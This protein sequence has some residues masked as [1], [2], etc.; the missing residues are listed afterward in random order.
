VTSADDLVPLLFVPTIGAA[1][2]ARHWFL[3]V[4][5]GRWR[6]RLWRQAPS[7]RN[8]VSAVGVMPAGSDLVMPN[9][10]EPFFSS[11]TS[12]HARAY[13]TD[14]LMERVG[15]LGKIL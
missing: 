4:R 7:R 15:W 10:L 12:R 8:G 11:T 5:I 6:G 9:Y 13:W 2:A 1:L 3:W 14:N